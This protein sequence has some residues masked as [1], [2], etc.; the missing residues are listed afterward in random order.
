MWAKLWVGTHEYNVRSK[1]IRL[2][3]RGNHFG[4]GTYERDKDDDDDAD[5]DDNNSLKGAPKMCGVATV[6]TELLRL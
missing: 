1:R 5:D 4:T 2:L 6:V 3:L